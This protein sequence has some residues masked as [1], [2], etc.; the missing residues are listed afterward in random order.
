MSRDLGHGPVT[1]VD[2][3]KA[4]AA[5]VS[6]TSGRVLA[7]LDGLG[8]MGTGGHTVDGIADLKT[9]TSQTERA[10]VLLLRIA[11]GEASALEKAK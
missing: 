10:A 9:L 6:F 5:D 7:A 8:L 3:R 11:H 2:P 4:G 1:A